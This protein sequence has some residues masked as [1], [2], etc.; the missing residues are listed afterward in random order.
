MENIYKPQCDVCGIKEHGVYY[1]V[2][3]VAI[4]CQKCKPADRHNFSQ[5]IV[6]E[7]LT[8]AQVQELYSDEWREKVCGTLL[9]PSP[10]AP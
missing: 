5:V 3:Q 9:H 4:T 7:F 10:V 8:Q 6:T 2:S 1:F